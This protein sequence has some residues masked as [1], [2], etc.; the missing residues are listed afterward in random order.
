MNE[1]KGMLK[2]AEWAAKLI[3]NPDCL[4]EI[5]IEGPDSVFV[6]EMDGKTSIAQTRTNEPLL[7][8]ALITEIDRKIGLNEISK[9][10]K[11]SGEPAP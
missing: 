8:R 9:K 6:H 11:N 3:L 2:R 1:T 7:L 5:N 4:V 10:K